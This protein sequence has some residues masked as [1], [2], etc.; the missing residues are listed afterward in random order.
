MSPYFPSSEHTHTLGRENE[1]NGKK[2][3]TRRERKQQK[4]NKPTNHQ[5]AKMH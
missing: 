3:I 1:K 2:T 5:H 4:L